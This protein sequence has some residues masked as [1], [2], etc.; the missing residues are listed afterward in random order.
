LDNGSIG[1]RYKTGS[2]P[3]LPDNSFFI[4]SWRKD[5]WGIAVKKKI[6]PGFLL[7]PPEGN[8]GDISPANMNQTVF[9]SRHCYHPTGTDFFYL[10]FNGKKSGGVC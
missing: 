8:K 10:R 7:R 1:I 9:L 4:N 3:S 5:G 2:F 6:V